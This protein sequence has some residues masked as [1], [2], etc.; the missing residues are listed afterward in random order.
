MVAKDFHSSIKLWTKAIYWRQDLLESL[1]RLPVKKANLDVQSCLPSLKTNFKHTLI[2]GPTYYPILNNLSVW[3]KVKIVYFGIS[4][5]S[6]N[7][8]LSTG[9]TYRQL[10]LLITV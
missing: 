2:F 3:N 5:S 10:A 6:G 9:I 8:S 1:L 4:I 7:L